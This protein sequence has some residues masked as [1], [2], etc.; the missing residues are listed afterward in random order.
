MSSAFAVT[1]PSTSV[2]LAENRLGEMPFSITNMTDAPVQARASVVPL[3]GAPPQWFSFVGKADL[4]LN[5]H[6]TANVLVQV[7]PPLGVPPGRQLFRVDVVNVATPE[8]AASEGPSCSVEVPP[9]QPNVNKW[10][11]PRG[12][13]A[14]LVGSTVGGAL[15]ELMVFL[16]FLLSRKKDCSTVDC[17]FSEALGQVVVL[18]LV[19]LLGL[20][21]LWIGSF[22]G[23]WL[24]LRIRKYLGSKLT[25]LFLAVLMVP[26]TLAGLWFL[27][28][29]TNSLLVVA[30]LAPIVLTAV[31]G[32][33]ARGAVLL[34][35][36]KHL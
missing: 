32:V 34:I 4:T 20:V 28:H 8:V 30:I 33:I 29:V 27:G 31:P 25:A 14:T 23:A 19:I 18:I 26:W 3:D 15:G 6:A 10:T 36:T 11:I 35:R 1:A 7:E 13:L 22:I 5:P 21:V 2:V 17:T 9:S 24:A 12:Y 16:G